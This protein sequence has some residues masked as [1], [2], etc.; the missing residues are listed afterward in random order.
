MLRILSFLLLFVLLVLILR[1]L[2]VYAYK[3]TQTHNIRDID[4][5]IKNLSFKNYVSAL[6]PWKLWN[7]TNLHTH[8]HT[9]KEWA[10]TW[11]ESD[12][13][14]LYGKSRFSNREKVYRKTS[15]QILLNQ[16]SLSPA[17]AFSSASASASASVPFTPFSNISNINNISNISN[18]Y[19]YFHTIPSKNEPLGAKTKWRYFRLKRYRF[20]HHSIF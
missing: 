13:S 12:M 16:N 8:T 9:V 20:G 1:F 3:Y 17:S 15:E 14:L 10:P 7:P 19:Y 6:F 4:K 2:Y 11:T 18:I 5:N